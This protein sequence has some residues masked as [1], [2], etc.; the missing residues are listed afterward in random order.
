[1][2]GE[3]SLISKDWVKK[4]VKTRVISAVSKEWLAVFV[5]KKVPE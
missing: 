3:E 4:V 2:C 5:D 1:M